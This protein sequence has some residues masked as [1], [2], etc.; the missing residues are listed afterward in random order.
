MHPLLSQLYILGGVP[1]RRHQFF[2][3]FDRHPF[4][5]FPFIY[6]KRYIIKLIFLP[7]PLPLIDDVFYERPLRYILIN[8]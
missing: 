7:N 4:L 1:K 8:Y 2:E 5:L 6:K 3:I